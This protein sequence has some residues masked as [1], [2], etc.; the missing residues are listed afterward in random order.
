MKRRDFLMTAAAAVPGLALM[1]AA[2]VPDPELKDFSRYIRLGSRIKYTT[3]APQNDEN[4]PHCIPGRLILTIDE[5]GQQQLQAWR[6]R[7]ELDEENDFDDFSETWG[8]ADAEVALLECLVCNSELTW[9]HP[10]DTG[11]L[12]DAPLLGVWG[13]EISEEELG[14]V[15]CYGHTWCGCW[16]GGPS[17][18]HQRFY[19]PIIERW[20]FAPYGLR[21]FMDDLADTGKAIFTNRW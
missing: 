5:I 6:R 21:S 11:D 9:I 3:E 12:T 14:T 2:S 1:P 10:E 7:D 19:N 16:E 20:G 13:Q 18:K 4:L 15:A 8:T 17:W